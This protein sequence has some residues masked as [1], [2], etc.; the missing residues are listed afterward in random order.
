[1]NNSLLILVKG[2]YSILCS[3][4]FFSKVSTCIRAI[5]SFIES[6]PKFLKVVGTLWSATPKVKS[7]L[8]TFLFLSFKPSKA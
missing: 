8:L 7:G 6:I 2:I 3:L 5:L 1:M 4:R